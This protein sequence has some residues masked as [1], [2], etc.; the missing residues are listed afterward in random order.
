MKWFPMR[1]RKNQSS[2][3]NSPRQ[4]GPSGAADIIHD[5]NLSIDFVSMPQVNRIFQTVKVI[6]QVNTQILSTGKWIGTTS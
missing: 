4:Y 2:V 6:S 1:K 5:G 3:K